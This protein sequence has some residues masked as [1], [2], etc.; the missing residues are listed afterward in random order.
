MYHF[1]NDLLPNGCHPR[2]LQLYFFDTEHELENKL[3]GV[4]R[5][6]RD[7]VSALIQLMSGNPYGQF[8]R[9]LNDIAQTDEFSI[10]LRSDISM[11]QRTYNMPS[12]SQVAAIWIEDNGDRLD[13]N[14]NIRVHAHSG[15]SQYIQYYYGCYDSLQYPLLFPHGD[16]G[17]HE[18]IQRVSSREYVGTTGS[19]QSANT[20]PN[21]INSIDELIQAEECATVDADVG[22]RVIL[23][24]SFIG[25]PRDMRRR[26]MDAMSLVQRFGKPDLFITVTCNPNWSEIKELLKY[27]DEPQKRPDLLARVFHARLK[28]LKNDIF[29]RH[30][31]GEVA[32]YAYEHDRISLSLYA[33]ADVHE[34]DEIKEYQSARWVSPPEAA[35][36]IYAFPISEV[37]PADVHLQ[38]HLQN[39]Q[40]INFHGNDR[41]SMSTQ[42]KEDREIAAEYNIQISEYDLLCVEKLNVEQ[43]N[44]FDTI[45]A[46]T[47]R[48]RK[49]I[50]LPTASSGIA[51]SILPGGRTAHSTFK[52]PIDGDDKYIGN[53]TEQLVVRDKIK[54]PS[55][56]I[57][58]CTNEDGS[59]DALFQSVYLDLTCFG[60]DP[61][62]LMSKV[63]LTPKNEIADEI[64]SILID[65]FPGE[66]KCYV[67]FDEPLDSKQM[68]CKDYLHTLSPAGL[69]PHKLI[70]KKNCPIILLRNLD[71]SEGLCNGTRLVCDSFEDHLISCLIAVGEYKGKHV[72]IPRI[73][74]EPS[75]DENCPIPFKRTQFPIKICFAMTINKAQGQT[76]DFVGIYLKEPVFSHGQLYVAMS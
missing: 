26:Y 8:F 68:H 4:D 65:R 70:L 16:I 22:R 42:E 38:V 74:L 69:P 53:G 43:R 45:M 76:L 62:S 64:N 54:I 32:A 12:T 71:P 17:W 40:Y 41:L 10:I 35:W 29:K 18:G 50:A 25:G 52:I 27:V 15:R 73:R 19:R 58:P 63:I 44:T 57:I 66:S 36:R 56:F 14:R 20:N 48:S 11:D 47:V 6:D 5:M 2:N 28:E 3:Q 55:S 72:F 1:V 34:Y 46:T 51:A 67:S 24:V 75:K 61:Y 60:T 49:W 7:I 33:G 13:G 21:N 23:P 31:F 37:K 39:Y 9:S 30:I 59:L